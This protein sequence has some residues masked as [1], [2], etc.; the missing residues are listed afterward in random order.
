MY[1]LE[2]QDVNGTSTLQYNLCESTARKCPDMQPDHANIVS[3][4]GTCNHLS[5]MVVEGE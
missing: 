2:F 5:R 1:D 3:S 4:V